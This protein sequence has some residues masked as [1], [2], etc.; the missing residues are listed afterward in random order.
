MTGSRVSKSRWASA[1]SQRERIPASRRREG[2]AAQ[3]THA[4]VSL[5][6][7]W[8]RPFPN[9]QN[10]KQDRCHGPHHTSRKVLIGRPLSAVLLSSPPS[11]CGSILPECPR[12]A[13]GF[14]G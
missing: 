1:R 13:N 11:S 3:E 7:T 10:A 5:L 6:S 8:R 14:P 9:S 4:S 12:H 2:L